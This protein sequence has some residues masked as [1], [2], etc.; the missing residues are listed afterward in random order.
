MVLWY[1]TIPVPGPFE[2]VKSVQSLVKKNPIC[3]ICLFGYAL[4]QSLRWYIYSNW[5]PTFKTMEKLNKY[6]RG[7]GL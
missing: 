1:E 2:C 3:I 5:E 7:V 6:F 4:V